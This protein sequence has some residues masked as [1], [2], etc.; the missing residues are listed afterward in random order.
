MEGGGGQATIDDISRRYKH[1]YEIKVVEIG[2]M[3]VAGEMSEGFSL[4]ANASS[5]RDAI[6]SQLSRD[7]HATA[8][9][10]QG[11]EFQDLLIPKDNMRKVCL[12]KDLLFASHSLSMMQRTSTLDQGS[13][14]NHFIHSLMNH[15][16]AH[17]LIFDIHAPG[18][19]KGSST[20]TPRPEKETTVAAKI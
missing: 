9:R 15:D 3:V 14:G 1:P 7:L 13:F 11:F 8:R 17:P 5:N 4:Y 10:V 12:Q 19:N 2:L 16:S 18:E 20:C 6:R